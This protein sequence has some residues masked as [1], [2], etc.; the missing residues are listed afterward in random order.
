MLMS[1]IVCSNALDT[2]GQFLANRSCRRLERTAFALRAVVQQTAAG[3][4]ESPPAS[5]ASRVK[6]VVT[7]AAEMVS[8]GRLHGCSIAIGLGG[9]VVA[10]CGLGTTPAV[11][12][13]ALMAPLAPIA[14]DGSTIFITASVTKPLA[15]LAA[16]QLVERGSLALDESVSAKIP[17]FR[18]HAVTLRHLLTHSQCATSLSTSSHVR[19]LR[20][21]TLKATTALL[22]SQPLG[23]LIRLRGS[24]GLYIRRWT[25][26]PLAFAQAS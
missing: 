7:T 14:A 16:L 13:E 25:I 17:R 2:D 5:V 11:V 1:S 18:H 24:I 9:A 3:G 6:A 10:S 12:G 4:H 22:C 20:N 15:A 21:A 26:T 19:Q 8:A 23:C